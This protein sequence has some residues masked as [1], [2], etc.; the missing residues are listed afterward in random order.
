MRCGALV[1]TLKTDMEEKKLWIKVVIF[2]FFAHKKYFHRFIKFRV[3]NPFKL[4]SCSSLHSSVSTFH[5]NTH[6][7]KSNQ[8]PMHRTKSC[9]T[10]FPFDNPFH[11]HVRHNIKEKVCLYFHFIMTLKVSCV[12]FF[13]FWFFLTVLKHKNTIIC[14]QIVRKHVT[15]T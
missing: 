8:Q 14:L 4:C 6:I 7:S 1:N 15:F 12:I 13:F 10:I 9:P 3:N 2:V 11:S 5:S